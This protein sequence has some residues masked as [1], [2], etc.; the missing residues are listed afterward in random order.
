MRIL[1]IRTSALGDIVHTLPVLASLRRQLPE[2]TLG[3]VVEGSFAPLLEGHPDLDRLIVARTKSWR[4][5]P[6]AKSTL[7]DLERF[8]RELADF[9]ADVALD[10]MGNHKSATIAAL[11]MA[12]RRIGLG[13]R[14][15]REASSAIWLSE[16][17]DPVGGHAVDRGLSLLPALGLEIDPEPDFGGDRLLP[18]ATAEAE[19]GHI[20]LLPGAGWHN[21]RYP[22]SLWGKVAAGLAEVSA[23]EVRILPGPGEE[24]LAEKVLEASGGSCRIEAPGGLVSLTATLRGA[25][26]ALGG[27]T[28]PLHLAQALDV[29]VLC[30]MGPTDPERY[31]PYRAPERAL[32]KQLPCSFCHRRFDEPKA[33]LREIPPRVVVERALAELAGS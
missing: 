20:A 16:S 23:A 24:P 29:P 33:C 22:T 25:R 31:G 14:H 12:D 10:L 13:R 19:A 26:L 28:G 30:L 7:M 21:K 2:A 18:D 32:W 11:T 3:W 27:D 15:R 6:L 9:G 17:C 4:K 1:I 5:S 8:R